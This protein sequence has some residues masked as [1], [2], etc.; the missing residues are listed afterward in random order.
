MGVDGRTT[1]R[2]GSIF[3]ANMVDGMKITTRRAKGSTYF[4]QDQSSSLI[5]GLC[6]C[7]GDAKLLTL[8]RHQ[9]FAISSRFV[10][11]SV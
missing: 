4:A 1:C 5:K 2:G 7:V 9:A 10:L 11:L 8:K 6:D 3:Y